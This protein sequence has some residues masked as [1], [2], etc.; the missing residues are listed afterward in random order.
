M[1]NVGGMRLGKG[2]NP[3]K[4]PKNPDIV[5]HKRSPGDSE[6][7]TRDPRSGSCLLFNDGHVL[8]LWSETVAVR[9]RMIYGLGDI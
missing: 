3:R 2:E 1:E 8:Q 7:R 9:R 4:T 6:N 5:H